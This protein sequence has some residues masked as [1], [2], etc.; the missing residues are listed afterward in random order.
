[1]IDLKA[2]P[3]KPKSKSPTPTESSKS[4]SRT[5]ASPPR[6][7]LT[8]PS[9]PTRSL[10]SRASNA[11][12]TDSS[13]KARKSCNSPVSARFPV[14]PS[15]PPSSAT[16]DQSEDVAFAAST[17]NY[18][19]SPTAQSLGLRS[20]TSPSP[21]TLVTPASPSLSS[22]SPVPIMSPP[23]VHTSPSKIGY[24]RTEPPWRFNGR[25]TPISRGPDASPPPSPPPSSPLPPSPRSQTPTIP[26][27]NREFE[28]DATLLVP[29]RFGD[30]KAAQ[31]VPDDVESVISSIIEVPWPQP[32]STIPR[33]CVPLSSR[34]ES[35]AS[36]DTSCITEN[37]ARF[38]DEDRPFRGPSI[39]PVPSET[40]RTVSP[41][42]LVKKKGSRGVLNLQRS[43]PTTQYGLPPG[44]A[45][46]MT[47]VQETL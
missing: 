27:R 42:N 2:S 20:P 13:T 15:F 14:S 16:P 38:Y 19:N 4:T 28:M 22:P 21:L 7:P 40:R 9:S 10:S 17:I 30:R 25:V 24:D 45:I 12:L 44:E 31:N 26:R 41:L 43:K 1:M 29:S 8:C 37:F 3:Q 33:S 5:T 46:Y 34:P 36:S 23:M 47:V 39:S 6:K 32:P 35:P 11:S 18:L